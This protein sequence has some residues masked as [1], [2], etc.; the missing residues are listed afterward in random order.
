MT[1]IPSI[2]LIYHFDKKE[3]LLL[4]IV[5]RRVRTYQ[6]SYRQIHCKATNELPVSVRLSSPTL[7]QTANHEAKL[8]NIP[9]A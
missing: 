9:T 1:Q 8:R 5:L 4:S 7:T 2:N 6:V 3:Y